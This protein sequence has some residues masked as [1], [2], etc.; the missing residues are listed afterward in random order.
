MALPESPIRKL[1]FDLLTLVDMEEAEEQMRELWY[2]KDKPDPGMGFDDYGTA[3]F[4]EMRPRPGALG[5]LR[6]LRQAGCQLTFFTDIID[7]TTGDRAEKWLQEWSTVTDIALHQIKTEAGASP[8]QV[9]C[10]AYFL[11]EGHTYTMPEGRPRIYEHPRG[12]AFD[13]KIVAE[14]RKV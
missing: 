6:D 8:V 7:P 12:G 10:Q 4:R 11:A 13:R 2:G 9:D 14:A 1:G 3:I 5:L